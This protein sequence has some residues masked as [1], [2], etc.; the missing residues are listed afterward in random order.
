VTF[1]GGGPHYCLGAML[2]RAEIRAVLDELLCRADNISLGEAKV[3]YPNLSN[4]MSIFDSI[5]ITLKPR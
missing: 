3:A 2:A 1:G 5:P 4:N